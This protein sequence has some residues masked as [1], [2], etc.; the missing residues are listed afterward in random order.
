MAKHFAAPDFWA[1]YSKLPT[2]VRDLADKCY[3]LLKESPDHPSLRF[4]RVGR[5]FS[6]RVGSHHR[7]LAVEV[8]G[9]YLWFWIGRHSEYDRLARLLRKSGS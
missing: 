4:K 5:V 8:P 3:A 6:A 9:G 2:E 1:R 7:A